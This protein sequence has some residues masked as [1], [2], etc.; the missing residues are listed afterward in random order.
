MRRDG[1]P[2][3]RKANE[4]L[5][6]E[7]RRSATGKKPVIQDDKNRDRRRLNLDQNGRGKGDDRGG[8][9]QMNLPVGQERD[10]AMMVRLVRIVVQMPMRGWRRED[11]QEE[12]KRET[13]E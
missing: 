3:H 13:K 10:G 7:G 8:G 1:T 5:G 9:S 2:N 4:R 12:K 11:L 6:S